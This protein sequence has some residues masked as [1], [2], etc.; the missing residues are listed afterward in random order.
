MFI[1]KREVGPLAANCYIIADEKTKEAAVIDPGGDGEQIAGLCK[2]QGF[3]LRYIINTHGHADHI[4]GNAALK[5]ATGAELLVHAADGARLTSPEL[6]LA[7]FVGLQAELIPPDRTLTDGE[8]LPLGALRLKIIHTPGHTAGG[9]SIAVG[10]A[11][12][13]GDT[14]FNGSIG[15]TD[16]PGGSHKELIQAIKTRLFTYPED[17]VVY[18]GHGPGTTIKAEKEGNPFVRP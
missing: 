5:A 13:T 9:I 10:E 8:E 14:L 7:A 11:L 2:Q 6:S 18:P 15:R 17:T 16:F 1:T 12:F 4:M 3:T